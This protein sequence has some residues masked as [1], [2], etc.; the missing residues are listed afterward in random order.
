MD[1]PILVWGAGAIGGTIGAFLAR[2]GHKIHFV[3]LVDDHVRTI[4]ER[5]LQIDGPVAAFSIRCHA[6]LPHEV[7]RRYGRIFLAV[8]AQHT[9][10]A[11]AGLTPYLADDGYVLSCQNGLNEPQIAA[12]L[13][14]KRTMGAFVNFGSDW[15]APGHITFGGRGAVVIGE[16]DGALT[17]RASALHATLKDFEPD[18]V[19][20]DNIYGYLWS[21]LA[22]ATVLKAE[23]ITQ[24]T[25]VGFLAEP[26]LR[27]LIRWIIR[28]VL[29]IGRAEGVRP[30]KFQSF[31]PT[32][33]LTGERADA[34][35]CIDAIIASREGSSKLYSG[36]WRDIMIRRRPTEVPYQLA[37]VVE[38][39][40]RH[41]L[42]VATIAAL[43]EH[44]RAVEA[45]A[46]AEGIDHALALARIAE[47]EELQA[48]S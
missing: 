31:D 44:V 30:M 38:I 35:A 20:T 43:I 1:D 29:V 36:V 16:L 26:R 23:G 15:Q 19:L 7:Q 41:G 6:M 47:Q 3:D 2:A 21:K 34:D 18:A 48:V 10:E 25:I 5:G 13:G 42:P 17:P 45:G 24:E 14:A 8:K 11:L 28:S 9:A 4:E 33:F 39:G 12:A 40:R 22:W 32:A 37:P 27:P 46:P